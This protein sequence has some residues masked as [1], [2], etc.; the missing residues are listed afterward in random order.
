MTFFDKKKLT[1]RVKQ[2]ETELSNTRKQMSR[3]QQKNLNTVAQLGNNAIR[4][5]LPNQV[6][7]AGKAKKLV[8]YP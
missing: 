6:K 1:H 8:K 7:H 4:T 3:Q 2:R 5:M